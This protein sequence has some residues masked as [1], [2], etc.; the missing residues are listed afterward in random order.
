MTYK[1]G[2]SLRTKNRLNKVLTPEDYSHSQKNAP[3]LSRRERTVRSILIALGV[4]ILG[5]IYTE[6]LWAQQ[7]TQQRISISQA[8]NFPSDI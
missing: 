2:K 1:S 6:S 3:I 5:Y 7:A 4:M 8:V